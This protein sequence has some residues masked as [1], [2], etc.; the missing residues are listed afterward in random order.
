MN[1]HVFSNWCKTI[2]FPKIAA[3]KN[4][5][6]AEKFAAE[7]FSIKISILPVAHPELNPIRIIWD[8]CKRAVASRNIIFKLSYIEE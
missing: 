3:T 7:D 4:Q 5:P 6:V 8:F 1:W 2:V